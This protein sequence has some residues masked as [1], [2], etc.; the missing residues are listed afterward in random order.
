MERMGTATEPMA[1]VTA[2][3]EPTAMAQT[4]TEM[5]RTG[6]TATEPTAPT[7]LLRL[8]HLTSLVGADALTGFLADTLGKK[9]FSR[10]LPDGVAPDL[11]GW[12]QLNAALVQHR[13]GPPRL[14]LEKGGG[15]AGKGVFKERRTSRNNAMHDVNLPLLYERLREGATLIL[16]AVNELGGPLQSLCA[17]LA[18]EFSAGSQANLYACWGVSQGFDVHWDDHDV[19]VIQL[20]GAKRWMLYGATRPAPLRRDLDADP[21]PPTE[22]IEEITLEAG[23]MLYLPRG[24]WHAAVG[25][26]G[27]TLHLTVGLTRKTGHDFLGWLSDQALVADVVRADLPLEGDDEA[28][29][30]RVAEV[31]SAAIAGTDPAELGRRFRRHAQARRNHRPQLSF[32]FIGEASEAYEADAVIRLSD[33]PAHLKA[34]DDPAAFILSHRG[35]EYTL[36]SPL[37]AAIALLAAGEAVTYVELRQASAAAPS[38]QV[39]AFV[40]DMLGRGVFVLARP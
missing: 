28:L 21:P 7:R 25:T 32:P 16:D 14:K 33:G 2:R 35:V 17:G 20:E 37:R 1:T 18:D 19:F 24:Y 9:P 23:D 15:D 26:G 36:A 3:T 27:P 4:V 13:L 11:F 29:G 39:A 10:C 8:P 34:M 6:P 30:R 22:P 31:L 40:T 12:P 5:A 38:D